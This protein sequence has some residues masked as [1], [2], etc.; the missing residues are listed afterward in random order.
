M[1]VF[2]TQTN[3]GVGE[4]AAYPGAGDAYLAGVYAGLGRALHPGLEL[5]MYTL[6]QLWPY[7]ADV[8]IDPAL[9]ELGTADQ[10]TAMQLT[11]GSRVKH[12]MGMIDVRAEVGVQSG[13]RPRPGDNPRVAAYHGDLELGV[14]LL[15]DRLRLALQAQYASGDDPSS[16]EQNEAWDQLYPTGHKWLGLSDIIGRRTNVGSLVGHLSLIPLGRL[17]LG[18]QAHVFQRVRYPEDREPYLAT[19]LDTFA[20]YMLG[21]RL[22]L[23]AMWAHFRGSSDYYPF[24]G[25]A[26]YGEAQLR[27]DLD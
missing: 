25:V 13:T 12:R 21:H 10:D 19:E 4:T 1:D 8:P 2:F 24:G 7:T 23:S 26:N 9:V 5:D 16:L 22:G 17:K 20:V 15:D 14:N 11:L 3:E 18:M 6:G 27:Y